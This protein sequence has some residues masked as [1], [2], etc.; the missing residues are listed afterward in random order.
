MP[1][2][3]AIVVA[4][5]HGTNGHDYHVEADVAHGGRKLSIVV[6]YLQQCHET[7]AAQ[8]NV[9]LAPDGSFSVTRPLPRHAG[10]WNVTAHFVSPT[11][12]SGT[13]S[14]TRGGCTVTDMPFDATVNGHV[15]LG[16]PYDYPPRAIRGRSTD[17]RKLRLLARRVR[18][19]APRWSTPA[20]AARA[21]FVLSRRAGCPAM[22]H[23]RKHGVG[24]WGRPLNPVDPQALVFWCDARGHYTLAAF[25]FRERSDET[26]DTY[27]GMLQWHKHAM[28]ASWMTHIWLV[29]DP[30]GEFATCA[31]FR[32]FAGYGILRY[33]PY[34][35]DAM[36][37]KPCGDTPGL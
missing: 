11:H 34:Y 14:M 5:Q 37:D 4:H 33:Q 18:A 10:T 36:V 28:N 8:Q 25:M 23:A 29:P 3:G 32:K 22:Q 27:D 6:L 9:A 17:A 26:P 30:M 35:V 16:N 7:T 2:P 19:Q 31:P 15:I 1:K 21:G 12:A 13:Y 24:V 20:K